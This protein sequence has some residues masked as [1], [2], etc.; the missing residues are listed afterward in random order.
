MQSSTARSLILAFSANA[1]SKTV[2]VSGAKVANLVSHFVQLHKLTVEVLF[3]SRN[4]KLLVESVSL[5]HSSIELYV[6]VLDVAF[7]HKL[8]Y[9][10]WANFQNVVLSTTSVTYN[11]YYS[12]SSS[13]EEEKFLVPCKRKYSMY[14]LTDDMN[15]S[16]DSLKDI[17]M[18]PYVESGQARLKKHLGSSY[19]F[20]PPELRLLLALNLISQDSIYQII[21]NTNFPRFDVNCISQ[22]P[23]NIECITSQ[24]TS[25]ANA[26][27]ESVIC[28]EDM[29]FFV[30]QIDVFIRNENSVD[31]CAINTHTMN[32][33][34]TSVVKILQKSFK[35]TTW[36]ELSILYGRLELLVTG[37]IYGFT[38]GGILGSFLGANL[39][40]TKPIN[41]KISANIYLIQ[42]SHLLVFQE[43]R[44]LQNYARLATNYKWGFR[45]TRF[46]AKGFKTVNPLYTGNNSIKRAA[47]LIL[48]C[49]AY[50][51]A[52]AYDQEQIISLIHEAAADHSIEIFRIAD[53]LGYL[54]MLEPSCSTKFKVVIWAA[55]KLINGLSLRHLPQT[56]ISG[57]LATSVYSDVIAYRCNVINK[58]NVSQEAFLK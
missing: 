1:S 16:I 55:K 30:T 54:R 52:T 13:S 23:T 53:D 7:Y 9:H 5:Y 36:Q 15:K 4:I 43:E 37:G 14:E 26:F 57:S 27:I 39:K 45:S 18:K 44:L 58:S 38:T 22:K 3:S 51:H 50:N 34:D 40:I 6:P 29:L 21:D 19:N 33:P 49:L 17:L 31:P 25:V 28:F 42:P 24:I 12:T 47:S 32:Y 10:K 11:E 41:T 8:L 48:R 46:F 56:A 2:P 20:R 35:R